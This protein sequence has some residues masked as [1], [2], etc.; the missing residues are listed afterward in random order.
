MDRVDAEFKSLCVDNGIQDDEIKVLA[1]NYGIVSIKT[2]VMYF[3]PACNN[4][5]IDYQRS[6]SIW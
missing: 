6:L 3:E 4:Q 1:E 5:A 2:C